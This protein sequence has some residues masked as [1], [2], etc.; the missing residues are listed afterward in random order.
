MIESGVNL[1]WVD[2][3][4]SDGVR[5]VPHHRADT[6]A[7][8]LVP[9]DLPQAGIIQQM[10]RINRDP[11][12]TGF[13]RG[14]F[15]LHAKNNFEQRIKQNGPA[16]DRES[17][18]A[19]A[20]HAASLGYDPT[21]L[22]WDISPE[23]RAEF[24][25]RLTRARADLQR[26][27]LI[28]SD[29]SLSD[30]GAFINR[31]PVSPETGAM[32]NEAHHLDTERLRQGK[33]AQV[34]RDMILIAAI[35]ESRNLKLHS[36]KS[37]GHDRERTSDLIDAM[38]AFRDVRARA[39]AAG[40]VPSVVTASNENE[41]ATASKEELASLAAQRIALDEICADSNMTVNGYIQV[42]QLVAEIS[43]RLG[44]ASGIDVQELDAPEPYDAARYD[45]LKR[46]ILNG[47]V[48]AL[49]QLEHGELRDLIRD[50][51]NRKRDNGLPF[52]GYEI[53]E[54]SIVHGN[55]K[56]GMEGTLV[57][58]YLREVQPKQ[59]RGKPEDERSR[60][61][62]KSSGDA[63][64][65][66]MLVLS[67]VSMIPPSVF[68]AWAKDRAE[69]YAPVIEN[70]HLSPDGKLHANYAGCARFELPIPN[71][72]KRDAGFLVEHVVW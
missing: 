20:F 47:H 1:R 21:T 33:P 44:R 39:T 30:D 48:N 56:I 60:T 4:V 38:N 22:K 13:A 46:A 25:S 37:Y 67:E 52:S 68:V 14:I 35:V 71:D 34:L 7:D 9:E 65:E 42:A 5:K 63:R 72:A 49:Y 17:M 45:A 40:I 31:L 69:R 12:A 50:T 19:P 53:A 27:E 61:V 59:S 57:A 55:K 62:K 3:G 24:G 2:A 36:K 6:G 43:K 70:A 58:G 10:G 54:S 41:L 15:I 11:V 23:F 28:Y 66:P 26:L 32:L 51:G 18:L 29:W 64:R 8:A 16:I